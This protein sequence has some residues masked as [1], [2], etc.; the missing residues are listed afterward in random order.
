[1]VVLSP[2]SGQQNMTAFMVA[3]ADPNNYG[4]LQVFHM[5]EGGRIPGPAQID[6]II[7]Q[8][9]AVSQSISL[10]NTNGSQVLYGNV[11]TIPIDQSLLYVRPLY[12]SAKGTGAS[13]P[14]LKKVI[15]V[16]NGQVFYENTLQEALA[17]AF[18]GLAQVTQEQGVGQ[19]GPAI[20][21]VPASPGQPTTTTPAPPGGQS[22]AQLL[23]QAE[24]DLTNANAALAKNP[25]DFATY[26]ADTQAAQTLIA[27]AAAQAGASPSTTSAPAA[28][29]PPPSTTAA[30]G[31]PAT[32][33]ASGAPPTSGP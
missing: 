16:Y 12:V 18:P 17:A 10:L 28:G 2:G 1:M 31:A 23:A 32:T 33:A 19:P 22:V 30:P 8:D 21:T 14:E 7:N 3:K 29:A 27:Q 5:P 11:L 9:V 15:V 20:P 6:S 13:I 26:G 25:P 24:Q 4:Q